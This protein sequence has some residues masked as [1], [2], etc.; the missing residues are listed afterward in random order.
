MTTDKGAAPAYALELSESERARYRIMA[1]RAREREGE[2]W[3]RFGA[4]DGASVV[5]VGCG[6]G[7]VLVQLA[8]MVGERGSATGVEPNPG[9]RA[10]AEQELAS[11]GMKNARVIA[12]EGAAT[13]VEAGS[14]DM[15][16]IR[17]VLFHVGPHVQ[18]IVDHA[19]SLL[20]PGG[21]LYIVDTDGTAA[22]ATTTDPDFI[23]QWTR[24]QEFQRQRGNNVDVGVWLG[25]FVRAAGLEPV[26]RS[27]WVEMIP[28][29][30]LTGGGPPLAARS[31]MLAAGVATAADANR[32]DA[33][34]LRFAAEPDAMLFMTTHRAVGRR[35]SA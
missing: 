2:A 26:D 34:R 17:H 24:Y 6:P 28:G 3:S 33:A 8:G 4:V 14:H 19:A 1:S 25:S 15:V 35:R 20:R 5:D 29:A 32:W 21:H 7:A 18:E 31:E 12:G 10:A 9:A 27:A 13:G 30:L 11:A 16:M 22:R 23:D